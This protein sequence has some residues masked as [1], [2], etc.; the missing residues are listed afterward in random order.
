MMIRI[1]CILMLLLIA[2]CG[3][4]YTIDEVT[5]T[6][7]SSD[8]ECELPIDYAVQSHCPHTTKCLESKCAIICPEGW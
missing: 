5:D 8:D 1:I 3:Q 6:S 7:C 4:D 2:G